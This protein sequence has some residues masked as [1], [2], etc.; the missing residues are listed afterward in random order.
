MVVLRFGKPVTGA[1]Q[2]GFGDEAVVLAEADEDTGG[3]PGGGDLHYSLFP[4]RLVHDGGACDRRGSSPLVLRLQS[5]GLLAVT[6]RPLAQAVFQECDLLL[7]VLEQR[8]MVQRRGGRRVRRFVGRTG[9]P[10]GTGVFLRFVV[11]ARAP[12][13][14]P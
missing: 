8:G 3:D 14:H 2:P 9:I 13:A 7:E 12:T 10:G 11:A 4:P 1:G 5:H 6:V